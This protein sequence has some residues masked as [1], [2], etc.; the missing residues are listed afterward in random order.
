MLNDSDPTN[1]P[2]LL[3]SY[4]SCQ[5]L[6]SPDKLAIWE[7][8]CATCAYAQLLQPITIQRF[9]FFDRGSR[10]CNPAE[11]V[12]S[13]IKSWPGS[14]GKTDVFVSIGSGTKKSGE[15][16]PTE[17]TRWPK[18]HNSKV[19]RSDRQRMNGSEGTHRAVS[20]A[21]GQ[22]NYFRFNIEI[23][24]KLLGTDTIKRLDQIVTITGKYLNES[25]TQ[26]KLKKC[27]RKL[28]GIC[29]AASDDW[30]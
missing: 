19:K 25:T 18:S 22:D 12:L 1:K 14:N 4:Y 24:D 17:A 21:H 11:D 3:R 6:I 23:D 16:I 9:E 10:I 7:A 26:D 27:A 15:V 30:N 8:A 5:N 29:Y 13:E 2:I 20:S 28:V